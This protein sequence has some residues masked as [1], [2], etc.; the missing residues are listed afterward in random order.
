MMR[1]WPTV[2][3]LKTLYKADIL[4]PR[5][6][7]EYA[8]ARANSNLDQKEDHL[9][10]AV[11]YA[12][13]NETL[14]ED[15]QKGFQRGTPDLHKSSTAKAGTTVYE[16]R[17]RTGAAWRGAVICPDDDDDAWLIYADR[18]DRFHSSGPNAIAEG[19][20]SGSLAP[21]QLDQRIRN[22]CIQRETRKSRQKEVLDALVDALQDIAKGADSTQISMPENSEFA[23]AVIHLSVNEIVDEETNPLKAHEMLSTIRL[24]FI[25]S[26]MSY[27]TRSELIRLLAGFIQPD[28][29]MVESLY[30]KD[31]TL[32]ILVTQ[33]MLIQLLGMGKEHAKDF[34]ITPPKP[35]VLHYGYKS[36]LT[37]AHVNGIAVQAV[38]G[39]WWI[40]IGDDETHSNLPLCPLCN[41]EE[42]W[43]Q[44]ITNVKKAADLEK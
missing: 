10:R 34:E 32:E 38:C 26:S 44:A 11:E 9:V 15:A 8:A 24:T 19:L 22:A 33:A 20:K 23:N 18:H 13:S 30:I 14:I 3:V 17:S 31:L 6:K 35:K 39:K 16:V 29:S 5:A 12:V 36:L 43:A 21:S 7:T 2:G 37:E 27:Q 28:E 42:P 1:V 41:A 25:D 4:S 40:P